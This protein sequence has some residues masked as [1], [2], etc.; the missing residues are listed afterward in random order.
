MLSALYL[1]WW[2][3]RTSMGM[4]LGYQI[5]KEACGLLANLQTLTSSPVPMCLRLSFQ[6]LS[7]PGFV[8]QAPSTPPFG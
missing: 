1:N 2:R 4:N 3:S 6:T 7:I 5:C 8:I